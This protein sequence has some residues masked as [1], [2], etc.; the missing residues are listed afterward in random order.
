MSVRKLLN[1]SIKILINYHL[2]PMISSKVNLFCFL[3]K[4]WKILFIFFI[5]YG[6]HLHFIDLEISFF[7]FFKIFVSVFS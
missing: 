5:E 7:S 2:I 6:W 1:I 4:N 3:S